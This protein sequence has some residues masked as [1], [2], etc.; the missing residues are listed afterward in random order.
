MLSDLRALWALM[1]PYARRYAIGG[2]M[3]LLCD[4]GQL[5]APRIVGEIIDALHQGRMT[6]ALLLRFIW[7]LLGLAA[8]VAVFRYLWRF[9]VFGTARMVERDL[10]D[11]LY[12]H[13][14]TLSATFFTRRKVGDLMA[15]A[16]NDVNAVRAMAAEGV[17][18]GFDGP[19][20]IVCVLSVMLAL[21]WRLTLAA[22]APLPLIALIAGR[23]GQQ[24]HVRYKAVQEA[25]SDL[26]DRAQEAIS[27]VRIVKGFVQEEAEKARFA[28]AAAAYR[29]RFMAMQRVHSAFDPV[30][31][32]L[33]GASTAITLGYGGHLVSAGHITLGNLVTFLG[34]LHMLTWPM[35]AVSWAYNLLQRATASMAR[36]QELFDTRPDVT[37]PPDAAPLPV[38]AVE[39]RLEFRDLTFSYDPDRPPVLDG[40]SL[41]LEP[42]Q[43][44]GVVG[45][46]GSGKTTL[47]ALLMRFY[48]PPE[49]T[50]FLDGIDIRRI[51]VADLRSAIGYVP[52]DGFLF[53]R[54][55]EQNVD[56]GKEPRGTQAVLEALRLAAIEA[57]VAALPDGLATVLGER[58]ITLSGGQRQRVSTARALVQMPPILILDDCLSAVDAETEV[59]ILDSLGRYLRGRTTILVSHRLSVVRHADCIVVLEQGRVVEQ[60]THEQLVARGGEYA[61]LWRRQQLEAALAAE[62]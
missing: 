37:D 24:T 8:S 17:M 3:L 23:L 42:G 25:F 6:G 45:R 11:R 41:R 33:S 13:L 34:W 46:T 31:G 4:L 7:L 35:L 54:S 57:E 43:V 19:I 16:T 50:V 44:L 32:I 10:R 18:A 56:F 48:E 36:L 49:G 30:I 40:V 20:Y 1:R 22:L 28:R 27:G 53:S 47:G 14:Q 59:R 51:K 38:E 55:L 2:L 60:G 26:S 21:D 39:G 61:R 15:H 5:V 9:F 52:Q 62:A 12:A 29:T 58:G